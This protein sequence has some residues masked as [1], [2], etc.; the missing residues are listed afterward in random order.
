M[1]SFPLA[2]PS[3]QRASLTAASSIVTTKGDRVAVRVLQLALV[4]ITFVYL[5]GNGFEDMEGYAVPKEAVLHLTALTV[6]GWCLWSRR[7]LAADAID[8]AFAGFA[9]LGVISLLVAGTVGPLPVRALSLTV[10]GALLLWSMRSPRWAPLSDRVMSSLGLAIVL[11]AGLVL[12][13]SGG[14]LDGLS[15]PHRAP[16]GGH[17]NRNFASHLLVL[18]LPFVAAC[19]ANASIRAPG[20]SAVLPRQ[21]R[22]L[23]SIAVMMIA[24]ALVVTRCRASW[25]ACIVMALP[26]LGLRLV[27]PRPALQ[28]VAIFASGIVL[29]VAV[30]NRLWSRD[31]YLDSLDRIADYQ[32]GSGKGRLT[33]HRT[34]ARMIA[35]HPW[36]GVGPGTWPIEYPLYT[37]AKDPSFNGGI[38]Q[39]PTHAT[40][41]WIGLVAERGIPAMI[42]YA[43]GFGLIL[44][45]LWPRLRRRTRDNARA[46]DPDEAA[47]RQRAV[48]ALALITAL[49]VLALFD[50]VLQLP[51]PTLFVFLGLGLLLPRTS[52]RVRL[53]LSTTMHRGVCLVFVVGALVM[54]RASCREVRASF[55]V[56]TGTTLAEHAESAEVAVDNYRFQAWLAQQQQR[57]DC[58]KARLYAGR[59]LRIN[60]QM[61]IARDALLVCALGGSRPR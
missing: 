5:R 47:L 15:L 42:L 49:V 56:T 38:W 17:G 44:V 32:H 57:R 6:A 2:A 7:E 61:K 59:A 25:V 4:V 46:D 18:G 12:I 8:L 20:Q 26:V 11:V 13:E 27:R 10:S 39:T 36:L 51:A 45:A 19:W 28:F 31:S 22:I 48:I 16:A 52:A 14:G 3:G 1:T 43:S 9:V 50:T 40:S 54:M 30:P 37:R 29:A 24:A 35:A 21:A 33:Q 41:D 58:A 55:A 53:E 60:P 23:W 34:T